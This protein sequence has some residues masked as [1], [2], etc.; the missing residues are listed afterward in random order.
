MDLAHDAQ[1][2]AFVLAAQ[3]RLHRT[4]YL[5]CTDWHRAEDI[6]QTAL[7]QMAS[8]WERLR[9]GGGPAGYMHR[10]VVMP[11]S[12]NDGGRGGESTRPKRCPTGRPPRMTA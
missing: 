3:P 11:R 8:R 9:T 4:A 6:V 5:I 12:M 10:A 1:F 2:A 7:S